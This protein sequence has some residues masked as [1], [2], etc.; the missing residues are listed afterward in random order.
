MRFRSGYTANDTSVI[1]PGEIYT[2]E[3]G[4]PDQVI[5][6]LPE[7]QL[8]LDISSSN[9]PRFDCNLN[10]GGPMYTSGDTIIAS[11]K[12]YLSSATP[13]YIE[14]P[15]IDFT[16][17]IDD[18]SANRIAVD[19]YPNPVCRNAELK[20]HSEMSQFITADLIDIY[21]RIVSMLYEGPVNAPGLTIAIDKKAYSGVYF[22]RI[23]GKGVNLTK[24]LIFCPC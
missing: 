3:I 21:G 9:Y 11:N 12:I 10:N 6:F 14:I 4:L 13:S 7:H 20:I 22:I 1:T 16:T 19:I 24:K 15:V 5:T 8:R 23:K 18:I 17:R 2:I